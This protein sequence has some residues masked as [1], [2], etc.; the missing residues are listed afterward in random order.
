M[1]GFNPKLPCL[2]HSKNLRS[3]AQR[4]GCTYRYGQSFY[5]MK[6]SHYADTLNTL[7]SRTLFEYKTKLK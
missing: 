1:G 6:L 5:A 4:F 3:L 2:R 7:F